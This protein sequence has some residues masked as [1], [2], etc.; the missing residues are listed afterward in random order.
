MRFLINVI[1]SRSNSGTPQELASIDAFNELLQ[2]GGH[3]VL[4]AGMADPSKSLMIDGR[5][6]VP[7]LVDG[8]LVESAE[9]AS[10]FWIIEAADRETAI[11]LMIDGSRACNRRLELRP[12]L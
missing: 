2:E 12:L 6:A 9:W 11:S 3:W 7:E 8:P 4:A 5:G 1:D 10:G